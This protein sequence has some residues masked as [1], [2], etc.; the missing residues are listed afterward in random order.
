M[1]SRIDPVEL[2]SDLAGERPVFH[3][4]ADF[5]LALGWL[6]QQ[7]SPSA[8][9]RLE[10]R[11]AYLDRRGYLDLWIVDGEAATAIELKYFTRPFEG[12][13]D[14]EQ[15]VLLNQG[16]QDISRYDFVRDVER[17]ESVVDHGLATSGF[18][19]ALTN[20]SS[21]WRTPAIPRET[22]DGAF[23]LH[24]G[25]T[26]EGTLGWS[27]ST[28]AGTMRGREKAHELRRRHHIEWH[29]YSRRG[30]APGQTFRYALV[31]IAAE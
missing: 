14:G 23:R 17:V 8:K 30:A 28:G 2:M 3:S 5:Q 16:A 13:V 27:P 25:R 24:E 26:L 11:A 6:I 31:R 21:Y 4:E 10:Y 18:A 1:A 29:D 9:V 7:R 22:A 20:D 12:A 19:I 15:F